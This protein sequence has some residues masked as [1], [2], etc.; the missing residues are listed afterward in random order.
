MSERASERE[1]TH[2]RERLESAVVSFKKKNKTNKSMFTL[3]KAASVREFPCCRCSTATL[4][5]SSLPADHPGCTSKC[6]QSP[7][8]PPTRLTSFCRLELCSH[9]IFCL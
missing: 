4:A 2:R 1:R 8:A 9:N 5:S 3:N 7:S 6:C